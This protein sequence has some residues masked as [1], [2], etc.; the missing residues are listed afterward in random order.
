MSGNVNISG[1]LE[2]ATG[3]TLSGNVNVGG[4]ISADKVSDIK[5][6][7]NISYGSEDGNATNIAMPDY[8]AN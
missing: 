7:G 3:V 2:G 5:T 8:P 6:S 4:D 1:N